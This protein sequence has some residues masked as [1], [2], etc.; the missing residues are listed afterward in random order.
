MNLDPKVS[1][2]IDEGG[3]INYLCQG[4]RRKQFQGKYYQNWS[5]SKNAYRDV[6]RYGSGGAW[7]RSR[8]LCSV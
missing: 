2:G 7:S 6:V 1:K 8:E 4:Y 5:K 3:E